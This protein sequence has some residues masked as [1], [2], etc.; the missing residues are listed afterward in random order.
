[1]FVVILMVYL[2]EQAKAGGFGLTIV[3]GGNPGHGYQR[4]YPQPYGYQ[5]GYPQPYGYQRGYPQPYG[6]QRGYS[7]PYGYQSYQSYQGYS[8]YGSFQYPI[9]PPPRWSY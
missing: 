1:M 3:I 4:G 8:S 6:Y 5:R 7:Q 9:G 2:S